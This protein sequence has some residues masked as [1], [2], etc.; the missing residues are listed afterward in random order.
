M[1]R[2]ELQ[3]ERFVLSAPL[4]ARLK[5]ASPHPLAHGAPHPPPPPCSQ[6]KAPENDFEAKMAEKKPRRDCFVSRLSRAPAQRSAP[7]GSGSRRGGSRS[8]PPTFSHPRQ[9]QPLPAGRQPS[10]SRAEPHSPPSRS[11]RGSAAA[12]P[13]FAAP[14]PARLPGTWRW[15]G[16]RKTA[17]SSDGDALWKISSIG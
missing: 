3:S 4:P 9:G 17:Q 10:Q 16:A 2:A 5:R 12:H 1:S 15:V 11:R 14:A 8:R 13:P 7:P 6:H